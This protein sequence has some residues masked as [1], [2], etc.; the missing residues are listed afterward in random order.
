ATAGSGAAGSGAGSAGQAGGSAGHQFGAKN[1]QKTARQAGDGGDDRRK[2]QQDPQAFGSQGIGHGTDEQQRFGGG[3]GPVGS[4]G[5]GDAAGDD[6]TLFGDLFGS[7]AGAFDEMGAFGD[8]SGFGDMDLFDDM[9]LFEEMDL[10]GDLGGAGLPGT[11]MTGTALQGGANAG[12]HAF[13]AR[14]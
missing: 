1:L 7:E 13:S 14:R 8:L 2:K 9:D 3:Q 6:D 12:D 5:F 11:G 10:F 4:A